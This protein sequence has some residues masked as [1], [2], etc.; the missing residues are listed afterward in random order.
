MF[1][2]AEW[3]NPDY[4]TAAGAVFPL[5]VAAFPENA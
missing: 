4:A 2:T 5:S 3:R 1:A